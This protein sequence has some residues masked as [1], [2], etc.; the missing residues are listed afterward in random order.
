MQKG[1][2]NCSQ[3]VMKENNM[4]EYKASNQKARKCAVWQNVRTQ[5]SSYK[6]HTTLNTTIA[7][8][9]LYKAEICGFMYGLYE[10]QIYVS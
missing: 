10:C 2:H 1:H 7:L 8:L 5:L 3:N 4:Q 9:T 6:E